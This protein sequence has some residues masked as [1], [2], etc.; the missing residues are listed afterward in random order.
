MGANISTFVDTLLIAFLLANLAAV[1]LVLVAM[2]SVGAVSLLALL[3]YRYYSRAIL[4]LFHWTFH[5]N[6]ALGGFVIVMVAV[7]LVLL[8]V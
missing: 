7:P 8:V 1:N 5:S 3:L 4:W 2:V 6:R